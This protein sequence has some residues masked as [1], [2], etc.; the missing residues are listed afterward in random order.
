MDDRPPMGATL[1]D[2][3]TTRVCAAINHSMVRQH[4][5]TTSEDYKCFAFHEYKLLNRAI[6]RHRSTPA[7]TYAASFPP[8]RCM[9]RIQNLPRQF[10]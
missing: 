7:N 8:N 3:Q 6:D 2:G 1:H 9:A 5:I 10:A 4:E